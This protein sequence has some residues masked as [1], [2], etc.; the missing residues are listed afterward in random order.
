MN[1]NELKVTAAN[2]E[3]KQVEGKY[4]HGFVSLELERACKRPT[5]WLRLYPTPSKAS[6]L[7]VEYGSVT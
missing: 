1:N 5:I 2:Q 3:I 4:Q 7:Q 6:A